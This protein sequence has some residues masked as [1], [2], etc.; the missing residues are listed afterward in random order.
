M[1]K[2]R[3]EYLEDINNILKEFSEKAGFP[4]TLYRVIKGE[5]VPIL[6]PEK[7]LYSDAYSYGNAAGYG[8]YGVGR[9]DVD[10]LSLSALILT[11]FNI[12]HFPGSCALGVSNGTSIPARRQGFGLNRLGIRLRIAIAGWSGYK[13]LVCTDVANNEASI[14]TIE[15]AGFQKLYSLVNKRTAN[16]INLYIKELE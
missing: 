12:T 9:A 5:W 10:R 1:A 15:G 14:R 13:G 4:C 2:D 16:K 6:T 3:H 8:A 11:T 7:L